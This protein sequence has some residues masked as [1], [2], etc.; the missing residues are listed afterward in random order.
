MDDSILEKAL[1]LAEKAF[2]HD[3]VPVGA[4]L[5]QTDTHRI[6]ASAYNQTLRKHDPTAHAEIE[7]L[8]KAC[9]K[10]G[11]DKLVGYS[12]FV[13][14]EPCAM[15]ASAISLARL[16]ALYFGAYDPK[17]GGVIQGPCIYNHSQTHH[18]PKV[19]GGIRADLYGKF[20][21]DFFKLKREEKCRKH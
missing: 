11:T 8:R 1:K 4:V 13:T 18:K 16:D 3:E 12:L 2:A 6:I 19:T 20:L 5:F 15:C 17:T 7:V 9:K 21:K 10:L 14:L